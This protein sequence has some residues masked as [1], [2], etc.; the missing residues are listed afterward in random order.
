MRVTLNIADDI[1]AKLR[2]QSRVRKKSLNDI[3]NETLRA[4]L[5]E[6]EGTQPP[7]RYRQR[8]F[9]LGEPNVELD[10]ALRIAAGLDDAEKMREKDIAE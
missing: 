4:G 9:A 1:L 2:R 3:A 6:E 10:H 7:R 5:A 8:V